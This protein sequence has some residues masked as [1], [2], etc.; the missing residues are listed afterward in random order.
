MTTTTPTTMTTMTP[1]TMTTTETTMTTPT[2]TALTMTAPTMTAPTMTTPT[3]TTE[4]EAVPE[5]TATADVLAFPASFAA[6]ARFDVHEVERFR[7]WWTAERAGGARRLAV[8]CSEV[9][10]VDLGAIEAVDEARA[11]LDGAL[12]LVRLSTAM[13]ITLELLAERPADLQV[14]A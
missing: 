3:M 12:E 9:R 2:M 8:D 6:P 14:A 1:T 11:A 10:F 7:S 5:R 13:T 4:I